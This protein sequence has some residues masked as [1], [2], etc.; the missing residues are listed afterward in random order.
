M[1]KLISFFA[2]IAASLGL[3]AG[4]QAGT[5]TS[6]LSVSATVS[7]ICTVSTTAVNFGDVTGLTDVLAN[8]DVTVNCASG[9]PYNITLDAGLHY[10]G[11][12]RTIS[13]G[14][15]TRHYALSSAFNPNP[16]D[17]ESQWG[18]MGYA[19]TFF[20]FGVAD[21]GSGAAQAHTVY[22]WLEPGVALPSG[23]YS[24]IVTVTVY[25]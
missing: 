21:T 3:A 17:T 11:F 5:T 22:G 20:G 8:G 4:A 2:V 16:I 19:D 14:T 9:F 1:K 25:Y 10:D 23:A 12:M 7:G 24:D 6:T 15:D 18:D 13:N